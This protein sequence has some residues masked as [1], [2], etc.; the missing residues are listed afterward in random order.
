MV[1]LDSAASRLLQ[2][3]DVVAYSRKWL[4]EGELSAKS[5]RERF[6]IESS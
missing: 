5:L 2:L 4:V 6:G 1:A 3:A